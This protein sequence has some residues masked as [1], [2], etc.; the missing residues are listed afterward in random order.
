MLIKN[1]LTKQE[2]ENLLKLKRKHKSVLIRDRAQVILAR[3]K[4]LTISNIAQAL[5]RSEDFVKKAI[6]KFANGELNNLNFKGNNRKLWVIRK[7]SGV[8]R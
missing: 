8:I 6:I 5:S 3:D 2:K 4:G 1:Q 7:S